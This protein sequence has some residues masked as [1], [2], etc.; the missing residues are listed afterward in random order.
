MNAR[1]LD[2]I[3]ENYK[4]KNAWESIH[5][6]NM[7]AAIV[8]MLAEIDRL[9]MVNTGYERVIAGQKHSLFEKETELSRLRTELHKYH[10]HIT[11]TI[12]QE[13]DDEN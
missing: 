7:Q 12:E 6:A 5:P 4:N 13:Y 2:A 11:A 1:T 8:D 9:N 3:R 10:E